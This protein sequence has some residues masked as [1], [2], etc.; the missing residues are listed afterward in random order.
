MDKTTKKNIDCGSNQLRVT[1]AKKPDGQID[2][3]QG[4]KTNGSWRTT[5]RD[6][7]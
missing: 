7:D 2:R 1:A 5:P 3:R 6:D 4:V